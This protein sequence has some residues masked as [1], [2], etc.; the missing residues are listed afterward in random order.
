MK[1]LHIVYFIALTDFATSTDP[2]FCP[3]TAT[4]QELARLLTEQGVVYVRGTPTSGKTILARLLEEYNRNNGIQ[5]V[6]IKQW[7]N[8]DY[9]VF[10]V[11]YLV[12]AAHAEGLTSVTSFNCI[13]QDI[14][15]IIDNAQTSYRDHGLW[16][17]PLK[18]QYRHQFGSRYCLFESYGSPTD[19]GDESSPSSAR[20]AITTSQSV[21]ITVSRFRDSPQISL[22]FNREEFDDV[23]RRKRSHQ[24]HPLPLDS[25][26]ADYLFDL[27]NGHPGAVM[28]VLHMIYEVYKTMV[29]FETY[30][31]LIR[32]HTEIS[33][34]SHTRE[35][36]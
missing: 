11:D 24:Q 32:W 14:T 23:L 12:Q 1:P 10:G 17:G 19:W 9:R 8:Q 35:N 36:H 31:V 27:T 30:S 22:F 3:R 34:I 21:S 2:Y 29:V 16:Y 25:Y 18:D 15:F 28:G 20:S 5:T 4:V 13:D 26:A 33:V 6:Y 7:P